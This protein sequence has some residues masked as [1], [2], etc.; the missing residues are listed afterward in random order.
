MLR[1]ILIISFLCIG[2]GGAPVVFADDL[3][4]WE[5]C[6]AESLRQNPELLSA[7][8]NLEKAKA[9]K[10]ITKSDALPQISASAGASRQ[11]ISGGQNSDYD[12]G[13]SGRQLLFDGF[14]TVNNIASAR[15]KIK[16]A[17]YN[18]A[19]VSSNIRTELWSAFYGLLGAQESLDVTEDILKR[20]QQNVE[21]VNLRYS[22]GREH[23]GS[24][25]K[26][27]ASLS[28]AKYEHEAAKREAELYQR[29]LSKQLGREKFVP[30]IASGDLVVSYAD[31]EKPD[32]ENL[33]N[34]TPLLQETIAQ[35]ESAKFDLKAAKGSLLPSIYATAA[36]GKDGSTWPPGTKS[37]SAGLSMSV[38]LF[39]GGKQQAQIRQADAALKQAKADER[40]ERDS[41]ILT[42]AE[43]WVNWQN[44]VANAFVQEEFF[45]ASRER[46]MI[47]EGQ[48][49]IG[50][51]T[52]D[53][54]T[55]IEDDLVSNQK[56]FLNAK[57]TAFVSEGKW[58]QA[59][60]V[61]LDE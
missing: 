4:A 51:V 42:L 35:R 10:D 18:Y 54:W 11:G 24:L 61:T 59:K 9:T 2:F 19:V 46:A 52:F 27:K 7:R 49:S 34:T 58:L 33:V 22:V 36:A 15:A 30:I 53:D 29:R 20:R 21:L 57:T 38:P 37:W 1:T 25:L 32:Y 17:E 31:Q 40:S 44:A 6:V 41:V 43:T 56:A 8:E 45:V 60:G 3:L 48:Y 13:V 55:I 50:M 47:V 26:A 16:A 12:Y 14:Q 23:K 39:E 5:D 28:Q